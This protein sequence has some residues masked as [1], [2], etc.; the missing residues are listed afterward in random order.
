MELE[1]DEV[2]DIEKGELFKSKGNT[3]Y[4]AKNYVQAIEQYNKAI[5][6]NQD[7]SYYANRAA[8]YLALKKYLK[9][10]DDCDKALKIDSNYSKALKRKA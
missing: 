9:C 6:Y 2:M 3:H 7:A 5:S 1:K 10:I 4:S 8:C